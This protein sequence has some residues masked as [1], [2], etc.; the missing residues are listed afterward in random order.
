TQL[1]IAVGKYRQA[2]RIQIQH[3]SFRIVL[4][5]IA[6]LYSL[7]AVAASQVLVA[8]FAAMLYYRK[9]TQYD[10]L[11]LHRLAAVMAPSAILTVITSIAPIAVLLFWPGPMSQHYIGAFFV[12]TAGAGAAWLA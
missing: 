6:A 10:E 4:A 12:A 3:Q 2:T 9:L 1:L 5:V 7:Q 11:K 8:L